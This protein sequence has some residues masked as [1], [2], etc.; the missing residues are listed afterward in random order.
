MGNDVWILHFKQWAWSKPNNTCTDLHPLDDQSQIV[1]ENVTILILG[2]CSKLN[3]FFKGFGPWHRQPLKVE[4]EDHGNQEWR[5]LSSLL[6]GTACVGSQQPP[7]KP[8]FEVSFISV[9]A[10]VS[11]TENTAHTF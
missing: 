7:S 5:S 3:T 11:A 10:L 2:G 6:G 8:Q 9:P 4:N 1:I